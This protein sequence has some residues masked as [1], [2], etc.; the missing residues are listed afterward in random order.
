MRG[1]ALLL[2]RKAVGSPLA[3]FHPGQWEAIEAL[4]ERRERLLVVQRTGWGKS[5]VYFMAAKLLR[6]RGA[7]CAVLISPLL[8]LMRNQM[9]AAARIGVRAASVNSTNRKDWARVKDDLLVNRLDIMLIS[10][11]RL[12][13]EEFMNEFLLP[14]AGQIGLFVVDEAHCISDWGH[15]F[16]PDYRRIVRILRA[17]PPNLP[18]LATTATA[19]D[20]VVQDIVEQ[21]GERLKTIRGPL[22]RETLALEN[23]R[24][25][26]QAARLAWLADHVPGFPGSG[27]I[28]TLTV[29][30]S[31][32]VAGWL[33]ERGVN[34][35]AYSA[36][37][38]NDERQQLEDM[39]MR[40]QVKALVATSALGMG[41]DKPD[42]GF[43]IHFQR[44]ASVVHYYQQ[45]G[46]AGRAIQRAH[47]ILLSGSEDDEIADYFVRTAF[48]S[49]EEV[50]AVLSAIEDS[51]TAL[52]RSGLQ[53]AVNLR[54]SSVDKILKF[55]SL[56]SPAPV[57]RDGSEYFRTAVQWRMPVER[58]ERITNLR[59]EEQARMD[60]YVASDGC[61]MQFLSNELDD[62]HAARCGK[63]ANCTGVRLGP[64]Y[65]ME[66]AE[67]ATRFLN[68]IDLPIQPRKMWPSGALFEG[69]RG[70]IAPE[71]QMEEGRAMCRWGDAGLGDLV[72]RGKRDGRFDR[73]WW[74]RRRT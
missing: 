43:A 69:Q 15:D 73:R 5:M 38:D 8:A 36:K 13:N 74:T 67:E 1:R 17:L 63:C 72:R 6:D 55:L 11:E 22:I 56:E 53:A 27:I 19:N 9:E 51:P 68:R 30:D 25:P 18:V 20:R 41:F 21:L 48:P 58:I 10:P 54:T 45:A 50:T 71:L 42:L 16:R 65:S 47:G 61:L 57:Q 52:N 33:Q 60:D 32:H 37:R 29:H 64:A 39:L 31:E 62:P 44:P 3:E 40:N 46:R 7:G 35:R 23:I 14:V 59:R 28:Y 34:A 24:I 4:V 12:G 2:L 66:L 26:S 70:R 49:P